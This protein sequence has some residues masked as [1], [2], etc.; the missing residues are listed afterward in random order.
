MSC[1]VV[2]GHFKRRENMEGAFWMSSESPLLIAYCLSE[3]I[4]CGFVCPQ[5]VSTH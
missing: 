1:L 5:S 3:L 4:E 2:L